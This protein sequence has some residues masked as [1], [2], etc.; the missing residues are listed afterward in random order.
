MLKAYSINWF[1]AAVII[2]GYKVKEFVN[3]V[4]AKDSTLVEEIWLS[5]KLNSI[6]YFT[7][8]F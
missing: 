3:E 1:Q 5:V 6:S 4:S 2:N 8:L 7:A